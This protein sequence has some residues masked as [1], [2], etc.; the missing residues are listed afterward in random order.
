MGPQDA[1]TRTRPTKKSSDRDWI[2]RSDDGCGIERLEAFF[3]GHGYDAHR[4]DTYAIG[5]T[6]SGVQS[7]NYRKGTRHSLPGTTMIIHPDE[8]HDGEAGTEEGFSYRIAYIQPSLLQKV[9]GNTQ[10]PFVKNGV[11]DSPRLYS[12][13]RLFLA[14]ITAQL[15]TLE[16]HDLLLDLAIALQ[17]VS[18][19][20]KQQHRAD[21]R[22]AQRAREY[23]HDKLDS[24]M[25]LDELANISQ[26]DRWSLSRDFRYFFGTSPYRYLTMRR[27][28]LVKSLIVGGHSLADSATI[29]GFSDQSHMTR[30]F[31]KTYGMPPAQWLRIQV[32]AD[33]ANRLRSTRSSELIS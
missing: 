4:H 5:I 33:N 27:L 9:L 18:D 3:Q 23:I 2:C 12:A 10:L 30:Q 19:A 16:G 14:D 13:A 15:D 6:M 31:V 32:P 7:F 17:A 24:A 29:S 26:R 20:P 28:D 22:A 1:H 8:L 25:T 11:C 21:F